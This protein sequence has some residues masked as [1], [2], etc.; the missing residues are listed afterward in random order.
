MPDP[1]IPGEVVGLGSRIE[2]PVKIGDSVFGRLE[3]G[4]FGALGEY[5]VVKSSGCALV[6]RGVSLEYASGIGSVGLAAFA[7]IVL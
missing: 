1:Y 4:S 6:P 3:L 2:F 7:S 5:V